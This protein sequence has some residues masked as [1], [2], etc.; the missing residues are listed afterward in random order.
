MNKELRDSRRKYKKTMAR[1]KSWE[2]K[3]PDD[4]V[5]K[6]IP[7]SCKNYPEK[8]SCPDLRDYL[9]DSCWN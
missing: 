9:N 2:K 1:L 4:V 7:H 8:K 5:K 6:S 3:H